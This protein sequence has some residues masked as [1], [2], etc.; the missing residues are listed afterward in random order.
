MTKTLPNFNVT[1]RHAFDLPDGRTIEFRPFTHA[2]EKAAQRSNQLNGNRDQLLTM[3]KIAKDCTFGEVDIEELTTSEYQ[4]LMVNIRSQAVGETT[5]I[6][7]PCSNKNCSSRRDVTANLTD[8]KFQEKAY[9]GDHLDIPIPSQPYV[10]RLVE[11]KM[12]SVLKFSASNDDLTKALGPSVVSM[13]NPNDE[14]DAYDLSDFK[15][16][17]LENFFGGFTNQQYMAL[18]SVAEKFSK[19][20]YDLTEFYEQDSTVCDECSQ[21]GREGEFPKEARDLS[22]FLE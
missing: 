15:V 1:T 16:K 12:S 7:I 4:I 9:E 5:D 22:D 19:A 8:Y 6:S 10:I 11:P 18:L 21:N 20:Y 3:I 17:D 13:F 14:D 2:E